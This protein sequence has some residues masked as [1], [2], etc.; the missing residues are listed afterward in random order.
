M[1]VIFINP[2]IDAT[3]NVL[4]M[5]ASTKA[6]A[7]TPYLKKDQVAQG[8]VSAIIGLTGEIGG[9]LSVSFSQ[10]C[11]LPI[12]ASMLGE[13]IKEMNSVIN[14]AVGEII[15]MISGQARRTLDE[16]GRTLRAAIPTVISGKN[17]TITHMTDHPVVAIPFNTDRGKFT[18]EVCFQA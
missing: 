18:I 3:L 10:E 17:H 12:V 9:T 16:L 5:M 13:E 4:E 2:F 7:G 1:D 11:V 14:D 6:S 15:N 8:D